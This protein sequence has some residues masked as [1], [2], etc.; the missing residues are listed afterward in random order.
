MH[1]QDGENPHILCLLEGTFSL[2]AVHIVLGVTITQFSLRILGCPL[3]FVDNKNSAVS[4][5]GLHCLS[6]SLLLDAG[7]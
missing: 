4:D 2:D 6:V 7:R 1:A 3:R 5:L